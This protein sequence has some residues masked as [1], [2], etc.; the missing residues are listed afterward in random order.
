[1]LVRG[2]ERHPSEVLSCRSMRGAAVLTLVGRARCRPCRSGLAWAGAPPGGAGGSTRAVRQHLPR[3]GQRQVRLEL[4]RRRQHR[5]RPGPRRPSGGHHPAVRRTSRRATRAATT[6][7]RTGTTRGRRSA[8]TAASRQIRPTRPT[9]PSRRTAAA[10]MS[11]RPTRA[12]VHRTSSGRARASTSGRELPTRRRP[13]LHRDARRGSVVAS[14]DV[15]DGLGRRRRLRLE[16]CERVRGRRGLPHRCERRRLQRRGRLPVHR[17]EPSVDIAEA[18]RP[19][20]RRRLRRA[21]RASSASPSTGRRRA[22]TYDGEN[23]VTLPAGTYTVTEPP[24]AG[25]TTT[26]LGLH[27]CRPLRPAAVCPRLHDHEHRRQARRCSPS[28]SARSSSGRRGRRATSASGR[29][30]DDHVRGRR[31]QRGRRSGRHVHGHRGPRRGLQDD[32]LR[33]HG[34]RRRGTSAAGPRLHDHEHRDNAAQY[35]LGNFA[36]VRRQLRPTGRTRRRS[37]TT[38]RIPSTV[39]VEPGRANN[40]SPGGPYHGQPTTFH[41]AAPSPSAFT[42]AGASRRGEASPGARRSHRRLEPTCR[43]LDFATKCS[44]TR[45]TRPTSASSSPASRTARR[46]TRA[47]GTGTPR[48]APVS[49]PGRPAES[50]RPRPDSTAASPAEFVPGTVRTAVTV[51]RDRRTARASRGDRSGQ[52]LLERARPLPRR[53]PTFGTKCGARPS[54]ST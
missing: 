38:T 2:V 18:P 45:P 3:G 39:T 32:H 16:R 40:V 14:G 37:V 20:G 34:H 29:R 31:R 23:E 7:A 36:Q 13:D 9:R 4:A 30:A 47:S 48:K 28:R 51:R 12:A 54:G 27:G 53:A 46:P 8:G 44:P 1:M 26:H 35:P 15:L 17:R 50:L 5:Q 19:Q 43:R 49:H 22:S 25:F 41:P 52:R 42:I 24:V 10:R 33:L 11:Q 6:P 21:R